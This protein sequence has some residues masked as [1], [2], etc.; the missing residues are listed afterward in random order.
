MLNLHGILRLPGKC[1][2]C[3]TGS[4]E[5]S[6]PHMKAQNHPD[7]A[8]SP[9]ACLADAEA[10]S[11]ATLLTRSYRYM[12]WPPSQRGRYTGISRLESALFEHMA[13]GLLVGVSASRR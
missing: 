11:A 2:L 1:R 6:A 12:S 9:Q 3:Q 7:A 4:H 13:E 5:R 8:A 10:S